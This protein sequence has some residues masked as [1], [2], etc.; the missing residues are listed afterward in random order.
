MR[1]AFYEA[2][3]PARVVLRVGEI[4]TPNLG[5][6]EVRV[7]L[8]TSGVDPSDVKSRGL[9]KLAF[10]RVIPHSDG[11]GVIEAVGAGVSESRVGERVWVWNGQWQRPFGTAAEF[12]VLPAEQAVRLPDNVSFEQGATLGIPAM[13][14]FHAVELACANSNT[15]VL[16]SGGAGSVS[17]FAI[18][19]AKAR[20]ATVIT[21][22]SS[23]DKATAA[24]QAGADHCIDYK[25]E[26]VG[27]LV[28]EITGKRG[29][30]A[31]I[32]MD[33]SANAKL[34]P[35]VLRPKGS[36]IVYGTGA[37]AT[38]PAFFCL[39]N[40]VLLQFFLV[41]QL[42]PLQRDRAVTG[43]TRALELGKIASR[44]GPTFSLTETAAAHEAV[45]QGTIGNVIV[46]MA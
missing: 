30:D 12:I 16:V 44:I 19:L 26:D 17:Q 21:T 9:R 4:E 23:P 7:R 13:T 5:A 10:P 22:I 33:L 39:T 14:A 24:G 29:V 42:D 45:E 43:I 3:G 11:A 32:E 27:E 37:E 46:K 25:R 28:A 15:T 18:Q 6:G 1:A 40:S 2:N 41:Y 38:V 31:I 20:G 36:V 35:A 8:H 34:I